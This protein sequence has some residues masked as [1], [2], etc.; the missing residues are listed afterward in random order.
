MIR[1]RV[2]IA[3]WYVRQVY[4]EARDGRWCNRCAVGYNRPS[5]ITQLLIAYPAGRRVVIP[6]PPFSQRPALVGR[7]REL[8][9][10]WQRYETAAAGQM[11]ITLVSGEPGIGKTRLL[12][13]LA[14]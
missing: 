13:E 1:L 12:D 5:R 6:Q 2:S 10:L 3:C 14:A 8:S 11:A 4:H 9:L 7:Q